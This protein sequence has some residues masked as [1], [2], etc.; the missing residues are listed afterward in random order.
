[1]DADSMELEDIVI[2]APDEMLTEGLNC[3]GCDES[4]MTARLSMQ[5]MN[6]RF[7]GMYGSNPHVCAQI[8]EDLQTTMVQEAR[9]D[10]SRLT[11]VQFHP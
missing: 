5:T 4:N 8:W 2:C 1:M 7:R 11:K 3:L 10:P 9:I 6:D